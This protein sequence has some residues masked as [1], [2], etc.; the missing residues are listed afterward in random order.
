MAKL[1]KKMRGAE[2]RKRGA[3]FK[4]VMAFK[5]S[6]DSDPIL[7]EGILRGWI[8]E[9]PMAKIIPGFPFRS[10]FYVPELGKTL[11]ELSMEEESKVAHRRM[12]LSKL[13]LE[14]KK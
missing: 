14:L 5:S 13:I 6:P 3:Q 10:V 8:T 7:A 12:A 1:L 9:E 4:V 11:G 2:E